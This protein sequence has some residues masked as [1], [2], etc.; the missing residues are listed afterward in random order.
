M[1]LNL[2][3][4]CCLIILG[5]VGF[6]GWEHLGTE[7]NQVEMLMPVFFGGALLICMGF[8]RQHYRHGL[9]GG[10]IVALLGVISAIIRIYQYEQF[11]SLVDP[12]SQLILA[13][14]IICALQLSLS[15]REVK[16]DRH[17]IAPTP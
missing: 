17:K 14:G 4:A 2:L 11:E 5:L 3:S 12:K 1:I 7:G 6:L 10:V 8:G 15:W 9:Y 13:M 16:A